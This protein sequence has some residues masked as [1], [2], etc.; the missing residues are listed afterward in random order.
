MFPLGK[1]AIGIPNKEAYVG[2]E[3]A[4][5]ICRHPFSSGPIFKRLE[6][7]GIL[8]FPQISIELFFA[9]SGVSKAEVNMAAKAENQELKVGLLA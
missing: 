2:E 8:T 9:S 6:K 4:L 7:R 3:S 5:G 1:F